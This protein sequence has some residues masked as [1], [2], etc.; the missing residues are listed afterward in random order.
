MS[1]QTRYVAVVDMYVYASSDE[2]AKEKAREITIK[3]RKEHDNRAG[4][5]EL[6]EQPIGS[7]HYRDVKL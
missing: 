3:L 4:V 2:E 7:G 5:I 6:Y 1:E